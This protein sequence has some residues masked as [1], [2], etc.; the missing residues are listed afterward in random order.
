MLYFAYT[1]KRKHQS[2]S[3][4]KAG[5][6]LQ[7]QVIITIM[8]GITAIIT[9]VILLITLMMLTITTINLE[10]RPLCVVFCFK[11]EVLKLFQN[12]DFAV[13]KDFFLSFTVLYFQEKSC[14]V[15]KK[16]VITSADV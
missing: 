10:V 15:K 11:A 7:R 8:T 6:L 16:K 2:Q 14:R 13:P 5:A 4:E 1:G 9:K 12:F 3:E